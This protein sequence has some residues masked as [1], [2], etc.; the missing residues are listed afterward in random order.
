MSSYAVFL[1]RMPIMTGYECTDEQAQEVLGILQEEYEYV[2]FNRTKQDYR[3]LIEDDFNCH[4][5]IYKEKDLPEG[6]DGQCQPIFR[7]ITID[8]N[9]DNFFYCCAFAHE[10]IHLTGYIQQENYVN[11]QTFRYLYEHEDE[12]LHNYGIKM[13]ILSLS[14]AFPQEYDCNGE[15]IDYILTLRY[16]KTAN[17]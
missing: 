3:E 16:E 1:R 5:Y 17:L 6:I 11:F 7:T 14:G 13:G 12:E 10:M 15:I 8:I 9:A 2:N 4:L